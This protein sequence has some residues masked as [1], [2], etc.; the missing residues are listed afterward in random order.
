[1]LCLEENFDISC[2][3]SV[4]LMIREAYKWSKD[5]LFEFL[6][7]DYIAASITTD[8]WTSRT[9]HRYIGITCSWLSYDWILN[10]SL[11]ALNQVKYPHTSD[12]IKAILCMETSN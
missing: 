5:W 1:L 11:L 4:K 8:F 10:E 2:D 12:A 3:K 9:Y 6:K 7:V